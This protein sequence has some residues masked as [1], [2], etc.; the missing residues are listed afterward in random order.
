MLDFATSIVARMKGLFF[1]RS[2]ITID[3]SFLTDYKRILNGSNWLLPEYFIITPILLHRCSSQ[4]CYHDL[5]TH[6]LA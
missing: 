2:I 1:L 6:Q 4:N 3:Y 5:N